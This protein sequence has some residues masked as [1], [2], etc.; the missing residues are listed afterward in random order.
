MAM[1]SAVKDELSRVEVTKMCCRKAEV[2]TMLRFASGLHIINRAIVVE[3]DLDTG[4]SARRLRKD[5]FE[6][7]GHDSEIALVQG[8]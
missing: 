3:A 5:I 6:I 2:S 4:S 1:T 7:Y 8:Y